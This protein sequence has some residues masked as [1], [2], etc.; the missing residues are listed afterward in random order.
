[1]IS[2][3][4]THTKENAYPLLIK[5]LH[6]TPKHELL[7]HIN[8]HLALRPYPLFNVMFVSQVCMLC[9]V[10]NL[11]VTAG[12]TDYLAIRVR[13]KIQRGRQQSKTV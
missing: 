9:H 2:L 3:T 10:K 13:K 1:M 7:H 6:V 11:N 8:P 5:H 4:H 12:I